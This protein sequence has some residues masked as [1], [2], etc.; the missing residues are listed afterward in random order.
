MM[1]CSRHVNSVRLDTGISARSWSVLRNLEA[2]DCP[3]GGMPGAKFNF[4]TSPIY[5]CPVVSGTS[6]QE[7]EERTKTRRNRKT[8]RLISVSRNG[9]GDEKKAA[10]ECDAAQETTGRSFN[11]RLAGR[12]HCPIPPPAT[13]RKWLAEEMLQSRDAKVCMKLCIRTVR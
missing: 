7:R 11:C 12:C 8:G 2:P 9:S 3:I 5:P 1:P 10:A 13:I 6:G 4:C